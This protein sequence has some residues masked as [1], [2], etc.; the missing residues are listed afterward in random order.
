MAAV[1]VLLC[2]R[3]DWWPSRYGTLPR[4]DPLLC[5]AVALVLLAGVLT[6]WAI[7][8][9]YV[10]GRDRRW[11]WWVAPIPAVV[12]AASVLTVILPPPGFD[13]LRGE[14]ERVALE[15]ID[16]PERER[17]DLEI[18]PIDIDSVRE[19]PGGVV[20]FVTADGP[21]DGWAYAPGGLPAHGFAG[22]RAIGVGGDWYE[23][24][25]DYGWR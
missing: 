24:E 1:A 8:A 14:F 16:T 19:E 9:L 3:Y 25:L 12:V 2:A 11:S 10:V 7:R 21:P 18:G 4:P 6:Q 23:L 13:D 20:Y 15:L 5:A 17:T 22:Y